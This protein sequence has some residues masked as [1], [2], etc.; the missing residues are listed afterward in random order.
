LPILSDH[1]A[2]VFD[3]KNAWCPV[4]EQL[5]LEAS[6]RM[7][8]YTVEAIRSGID[9]SHVDS[10]ARP[11]DDLFAMSTAAGLVEY[12]IPADRAEPDGAL[13]VA[14]RPRRGAGPRT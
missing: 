14:V 3:F 2:N 1:K 10:D 7:L 6:G 9:L 5:T 13:P 8:E 4:S 11:Q 12:K